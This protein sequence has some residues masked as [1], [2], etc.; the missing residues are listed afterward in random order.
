[1]ILLARHGETDDNAEPRRFMGLRDTPLN[2]RGR[3]QARA[4]APLAVQAGPA[5]VWSSHLRRARETAQIA[6]APLGLEVRV[7]ERL[8]E[9]HRGRWEGMLVADIERDEPDLWAAW[10]RAGAGFRFPSGESLEEHQVRALAAL[11]DVRGGPLPAL[12]VAHRGTIRAIAAAGHPR[13]LD[14]FHDLAVPNG[15]LLALD[16]LGRW[17][18]AA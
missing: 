7:D 14:A 3:E 17:T 8:A 6:A 11:D 4:L 5:A 1:V 2:E 15:A 16:D 10:R 18:I 12:V 13:G 9:S